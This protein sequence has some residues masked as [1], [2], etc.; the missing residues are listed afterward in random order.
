MRVLV[1]GARDYE[2]RQFIFD[3]LDELHVKDRITAIIEG[4]A[5]G[6]DSFAAE[7]AKLN[8]VLH[9]RFEAQWGDYGRAAGPIRNRQ[10]LERGHP[11][12]VLAFPK[13]TLAY[14]KGTKNMVKQAEK[15]RVQTI[16]MER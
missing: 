9:I 8:R 14:S 10:M 15:A 12:L 7:W 16:V 5:R 1:C 11:D 2:D 6:A 4:G 3:T 13:T